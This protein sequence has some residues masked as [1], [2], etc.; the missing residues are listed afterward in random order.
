VR[1]PRGEDA[2]A[3]ARA[4]ASGATHSRLDRARFRL[5]R[6]GT[7]EE[8]YLDEAVTLVEGIRNE[9]LALAPE[10]RTQPRVALAEG[11]SG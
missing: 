7:E 4:R 8:A 1:L 6:G 5:P 3:F 9:L 10:K 11:T 2:T